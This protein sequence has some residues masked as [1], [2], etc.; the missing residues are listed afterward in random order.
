MRN[1]A[2]LGMRAATW[3]GVVC[4]LPWGAGAASIPVWTPHSA[5][6]PWEEA[7]LHA[8]FGDDQ[9]AYRDVVPRWL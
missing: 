5:I 7:A 1:P 3:P 9:V 8:H 4:G 2:Y 6:L